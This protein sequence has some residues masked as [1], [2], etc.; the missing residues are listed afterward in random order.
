MTAKERRRAA[1]KETTYEELLE[2]MNQICKW[3]REDGYD[4]S[5]IETALKD[6]APDAID[7]EGILIAMDNYY[8]NVPQEEMP[9]FY[10]PGDMKRIKPQYEQIAG[11]CSCICRTAMDIEEKRLMDKGEL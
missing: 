3:I 9:S 11:Y 5:P 6:Q 10:Q 2:H 8:D 7:T 1:L 4:P